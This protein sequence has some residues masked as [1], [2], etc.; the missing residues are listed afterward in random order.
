M[1]VLTGVVK[2]GAVS[3]ISDAK[4]TYSL[5]VV[6]AIE[7]LS[8]PQE[9]DSSLIRPGWGNFRSDMF[10]D[11]R[12]DLIDRGRWLNIQDVLSKGFEPH[13]EDFHVRRCALS[14]VSAVRRNKD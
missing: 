8:F 5:F 4:A 12:F 6:F 1:L 9:S 13:R 14:N 11:Q 10:A 3:D 2:K 7:W